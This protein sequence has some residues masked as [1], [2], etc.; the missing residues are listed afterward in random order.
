M[1]TQQLFFFSKLAVLA[2]SGCL[3]YAGCG[4]T[5]SKNEVTSNA[6]SAVETKKTWIDP[7][8]L[9]LFM[10]YDKTSPITVNERVTRKF[11]YLNDLMIVI[12]DFTNGPQ[13][14]PDPVHSHVAE[15]VSYV[16]DGEVLVIIG[17]KRQYLKTGD[18]FIVPSDVLHTTQMLTPTLRLVD[19]FNPIREDFLPK[20]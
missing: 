12:V 14:E 6:V 13:T 16:A 4:N 20:E 5:A 19:I 9:N 7:A 3:L 18:V 15:Q 2:F 1:N 11:T 10:E 8:T 17:D